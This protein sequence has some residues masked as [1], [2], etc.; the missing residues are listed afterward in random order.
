VEAPKYGS[1]TVFDRF[2]TH[3]FDKIPTSILVIAKWSPMAAQKGHNLKIHELPPKKNFK[4]WFWGI[5][6]YD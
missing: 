6:A 5:K 3:F 4:K 2:R 1:F